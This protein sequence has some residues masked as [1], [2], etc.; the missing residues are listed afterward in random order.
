[1]GCA[2]GRVSEAV[3]RNFLVK[4]IIRD[5]IRVSL[6]MTSGVGRLLSCVKSMMRHRTVVYCIFL[7]VRNFDDSLFSFSLLFFFLF[8]CVMYKITYQNR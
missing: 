8:T 1:M 5:G 2:C 4:F 7:S 6:G 3:G